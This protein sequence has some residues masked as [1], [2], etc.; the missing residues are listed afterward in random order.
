MLDAKDMKESFQETL[1][2]QTKAFQETLSLQT[3]AFLEALSLQSKE[4]IEKISTI[5]AIPAGFIQNRRPFSSASRTFVSQVVSVLKLHVDKLFSPDLSSYVPE[6]IQP[7]VWSQKREPEES[8]LLLEFL[9]SS[10]F[11]DDVHHRKLSGHYK[12]F[13]VR[14]IAR[15]SHVVLE[16][17]NLAYCSGVPDVIIRYLGEEESNEKLG[18]NECMWI[19]WKT[20][21][22]MSEMATVEAIG[23]IQAIA[24]AK[25]ACNRRRFFPVIHTDMKRFRCWVCCESYVYSVHKSDRDLT[26]AEGIGLIRFFLSLELDG[27]GV[28]VGKNGIAIVDRMPSIPED[29]ASSDDDDAA[30]SNECSDSDSENHADISTQSRALQSIHDINSIAFAIAPFVLDKFHVPYKY[31]NP[32]D[33]L[34]NHPQLH[35]GGNSN[36]TD[37]V[38]YELMFEDARF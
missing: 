23:R 12:F 5:Q 8:N 31:V 16:I 14:N 38:V 15:S 30:E 27:K 36:G 29:K 6:F 22:A 3:K 34:E 18:S 7:Y 11:A 35:V 20:E 2:L 13:D 1:S 33:D 19:D 21:T 37:D 28:A 4:L 24:W 9:K 17:S 10:I 25:K 26:L 32:R